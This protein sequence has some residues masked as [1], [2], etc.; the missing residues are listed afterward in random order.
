[1][2][3]VL[4]PSG[5]LPPRVYWV[6]RLLVLAVVLLIV[7]TTWGLLGSRGSADP[8]GSA[9]RDATLSG[10]GSSDSSQAPPS[11]TTAPTS[12]TGSPLGSQVVRHRQT[13]P[14]HRSPAGVGTVSPPSTLAPPTGTCAPDNVDIV[15]SAA[16]AT[17]GQGTT[18]TLALT[19][20]D[21]TACT[22]QI[23]PAS[24]VVRVIGGP[25]VV[26]TS[27]DC[28]NLLPARQVVVRAD[29]ATVY[30]WTW[31][32]RDSVQGCVSPGAVA[33]PGRYWV[34]A[35]LVG[36]DVHKAPFDLTR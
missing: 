32:G 30:R 6:R 31:D 18:A 2:S 23:T 29:P 34:E 20:R 3:S 12:T 13:R 33:T 27:D 14:G 19:T 21:G 8:S 7:A 17:V 26:W 9:K 35:A 11:A 28:P 10:V 16:D 15:V 36:S 5:P 25:A 1:M 22:L 4:R 24:M